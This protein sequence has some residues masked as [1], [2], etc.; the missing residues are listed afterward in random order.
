MMSSTPTIIRLCEPFREE[1]GTTAIEYG[2]VAALVA[3]FILGA[4]GALGDTLVGIIDTT[5][6]A[7][8]T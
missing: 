6:R 1:A 4:I 7:M 5:V 8:P 3:V 2:L